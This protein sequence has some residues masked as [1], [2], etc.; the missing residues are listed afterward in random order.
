MEIITILKA[1]I[2]RQ[3][4]SFFGIFILMLIVSM[5][6]TAVL[7]VS[8]NSQKSDEEALEQAGFG[9]MLV[10]LN[11]SKETYEELIQQ[12]EEQGEVER[13]LI[14]SA[15]AG[16][17]LDINGE[18]ESNSVMMAGYSTSGL[19]YRIFN[20]EGTGYQEEPE[21]LKAGEMYVPISYRTLYGCETGDK[22]TLNMEGES[23]AYTIKGFFED[24]F[25]GSSMMGVKTVLINDADLE[26]MLQSCREGRSGNSFA[27]AVMLNI[28][29]KESSDLSYL[30]FQQELNKDTGVEGYAWLSLGKE[31]AISYMLI[32]VRIFSGSL[33]VFIAL[34]LIITLI[35]MS[36]SIGSSI[37]MEYVNLGILKAVGVTQRR[38]KM[39][40]MLQY[41]LSAAFGAVAGIPLAIPVIRLVNRIMTPVV[42]FMTPDVLAILPCFVTLLGIIVF[43][44]LFIWIKLRKLKT[45]TPVQAISGGRES[46]Y[47]SSR[48]EMPIRKR[49]MSFWLAF[50]Q[51]TSNGKQ[52]ISAGVITGLLVFFMIMMGH[53]SAW[54]GEDGE[55]FAR[56]FDATEYDLWVHCYNDEI[57]EA[58]E[59]T[60]ESYSEI[61]ESYQMQNTYLLLDGCQIQCF[62]CEKPEKIESVLEG[63]TCQYDNE[64]LVTEFV[65]KE[66]GLQ[67]GDTVTVA[68]NDEKAEYMIS[69]I[70]QCAND[71]GSNFAMSKAG[72]ERIALSGSTGEESVDTEEESMGTGE[73]SV[74]TEKKSVSRGK[75]Y[76]LADGEKAEEIAEKLSQVYGS[77][78]S[79][80]GSNGFN[81]MDSIVAAV[82]AL[83]VLVYVLAVIFALV[84]ISLVCG[85]IFAKERQDYGIYKA[86]GFTSGNLRLQFGLRF[87]I[88][89]LLGSVLGV[90]LT[91]LLMNRCF[92]L[93]LSYVGISKMETELV[94][95]SVLAPVVMMA[96]VFFLFSYWKAGR[97]KRVQARILI[98]E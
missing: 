54:M 71:M 79:A 13:V 34:L 2:R 31:Q 86:L 92:E 21:G 18:N 32:L 36:H 98:S 46:I 65:A 88:V 48:L 66:L 76:C 27:E 61:E 73:E 44:V 64:I 24:P 45:I 26:K 16:D 3:K 15:L 49:G 1:N 85:K 69:G 14:T 10:L 29:Q 40:F 70:Y 38:L 37:E 58:V 7:T 22:I 95:L 5:A 50:R 57:K 96:V 60:I 72:Y 75:A 30:R 12:V 62:I 35:I 23:T 4:G 56:I 17:F 20:E 94:W 90:V 91:V 19:N 52:Y 8:L 33:L 93:L 78:L 59:E 55:Q 53:M 83:S 9:D 82:N 68:L 97:I 89:S 28:F 63:R 41:L 80:S 77:K 6:L 81:G 42:G 84:V 43:I 39:I 25:M 67:I 47:F 11:G 87:M 74:D 51:L